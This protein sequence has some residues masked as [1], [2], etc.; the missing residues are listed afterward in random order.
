MDEGE[1]EGEAG[2]EV[3]VEAST[4][5][6]GGGAGSTLTEE[7]LLSA[8]RIVNKV[9]NTDKQRRYTVHLP[10]FR[11]SR[12]HSSSCRTFTFPRSWLDYMAM[13]TAC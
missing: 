9:T 2:G 4:S 13:S 7:E 3:K 10:S 6:A 11:S 1:A 12:A 5:E 8:Y